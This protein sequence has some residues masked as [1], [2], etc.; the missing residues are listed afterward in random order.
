M[1]TRPTVPSD[2]PSLA[3]L[4]DRTGMFKPIEIEALGEVLHDYHAEEQ[5]NGH[6]A[7]TA[8]IDGQ[9][10]GFMYYAP[11]PMTDNTWYLYWIAV[12]PALHGRGLGGKMLKIAEEHMQKLGGRVLFVE[13][14]ST[15]HY[16]PTRQFY[17]K[18]GYEITGIIEQF[19]HDDDDMVVFRKRLR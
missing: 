17:L 11:A 2:T 19:Y 6:F 7:V 1:L 3:A 8:E 14:S 9:I 12:E 13:T 10:V 4:A 16:E 5:A 15:P 18:K